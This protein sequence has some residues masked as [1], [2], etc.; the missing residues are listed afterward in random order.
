MPPDTTKFDFLKIRKHVAHLK[1]NQKNIIDLAYFN[2]YTQAEIAKDLKMPLG[3]VKKCVMACLEKKLS[4][5][6]NY[7]LKNVTP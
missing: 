6:N 3:S 5:G 7:C 4:K 2:G 1:P